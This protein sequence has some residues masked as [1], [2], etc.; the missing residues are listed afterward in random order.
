MKSKFNTRLLSLVE[1]ALM[2]A[3]S[4][5]LDLLPMPTWPQGGSITVAMVP[6]VYYSYR[7]GAKWGLMAG[8]IYSAIQILTGWY[9]PPAGTFTA[10]VLC[11]LLDY[12]LAFAVLGAADLFAKAFVKRNRLFGYGF[13]AL[14]VTLIR[15]LCSFLSGVLLWDSY[16]PEGVNVWVYSLTY[17]GSYMVPNAILTALLAVVLCIAVDPQTLKPMKKK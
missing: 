4:I 13:G 16:A 1:G 2:I 15:F 10:L 9:A 7:R 5:V 6:I 12:V 17:N 11:V 8:L 3:L 14:A